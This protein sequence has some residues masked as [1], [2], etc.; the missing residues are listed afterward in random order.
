MKP[1]WAKLKSASLLIGSI[2][3]AI[4]P[5]I[6]V[7]L[8][9]GAYPGYQVFRYVW[10]DDRFCM[11]CH[12]HDY[13]NVGWSKSAH[14]VRTTCHDCHHQPLRAYIHETIV[15]IRDR[16]KFPKD[17]HHTPFV[18]S[19]LCAACHVSTHKDLSS[20]TGPMS[21]AEVERLP[22]VDWSRL[23]K[24]HL[25]K[26]TRYTLTNEH[27]IP[28]Q[29]RA[30]DPMPLRGQMR[31]LGPEREIVCADCHGGTANRGHNFSATDLSCLRC[32]DRHEGARVLAEQG[33]RSC[34]FQDFLTPSVRKPALG[35]VSEV[36]GQK[37]WINR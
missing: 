34:H 8:L 11:S 33:C 1:S 10:T 4:S 27:A 37:A 19:D 26:I 29:E 5:G 17:L 25:G 2:L 20:I 36:S 35:E 12:V 28:D 15:M 30:A 22:K 31:D 3:V 21:R 13:A 9:L 32:H 7:G 18:K 24:A 14:G 6:G 23:H 16:P